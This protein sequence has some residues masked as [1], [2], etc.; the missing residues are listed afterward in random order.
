MQLEIA[1]KATWCI[2]HSFITRESPTPLQQDSLLTLTVSYEIPQRTALLNKFC[3]DNRPSQEQRSCWISGHTQHSACDCPL[4]KNKKLPEI[5]CNFNRLLLPPVSKQRTSVHLDD[6]INVF[7][8]TNRDVKLYVT[9]TCQPNLWWQESHS[10]M[11]PLM[12]NCH[13]SIRNKL[14]LAYQLWSTQVVHS[15][16]AISSELLLSLL[17]RNFLYLLTVAVQCLF[18][19]CSHADLVAS[20]CPQL[21]YQLLPLLQKLSCKPSAKWKFQ[22]NGTQVVMKMKTLK[23]KT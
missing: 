7:S 6:F 22:Y 8:V 2:Q 4:K 23:R 16:S 5:C 1:I 3:G 13:S 21:K 10:W 12:L 14:Y 18:V 9:K 17:E 19:S 20:K 15:K 11:N